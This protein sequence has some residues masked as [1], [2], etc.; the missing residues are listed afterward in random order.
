MRV[1]ESAYDS[2]RV[3]GELFRKD[4]KNVSVWVFYKSG[5]IGALSLG[6]PGSSGVPWGE[7]PTITV[8]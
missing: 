4:G 8:F 1:Y 5:Y 6:A 7:P 2:A 3:T